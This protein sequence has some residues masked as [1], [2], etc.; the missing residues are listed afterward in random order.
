MTVERFNAVAVLHT[1][2]IAVACVL[3]RH[4][5][6][7]VKGCA[8]VVVG[9]GLD[10]H[11]RMT[12]TTSATKRTYHLTVFQR[13]A[14]LARRESGEIKHHLV[15][16]GKRIATSFLLRRSQS[17]VLLVLLSHTDVH[18]C[19]RFLAE[20]SLLQQPVTVCI[21]DY[22]GVNATTV[23]HYGHHTKRA[24]VLSANDSQRLASLYAVA[25]VDKVLR[26]APIHGLQAVVVAHYDYVAH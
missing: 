8:D 6:H 7:T 10:V 4:R 24:S 13:I 22:F 9:L 21:D 18:V 15:A 3:L 1:Y 20:Y 16:F 23:D 17:R 14:P 2:A 11:A 19:T 5:Y 26:I 12:A 25:H